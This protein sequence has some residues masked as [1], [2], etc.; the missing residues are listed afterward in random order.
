M[1]LVQLI[2][3]CRDRIDD[4]IEPYLI[5]DSE[6]TRYAIHAQYEAAERALLLQADF[7]VDVVAGQAAYELDPLIITPIRASLDDTKSPLVQVTTRALD[8]AWG[9]WE[10]VEG[11]PTHYTQIEHSIRLYPIPVED[12]VLTLRAYHYPM[13]NLGMPDYLD[14]EIQEKDHFFLTHWMC[15]EAMS[16]VDTELHSPKLAEKEY[17]LFERRFGRARDANELRNWRELPPNM[18]SVQRPMA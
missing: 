2:E 9:A 18:M 17:A 15:Y 8:R 16:K 12:G 6:W 10:F 3:V 7:A 1:D 13:S 11:R 4:G 5:P 14:L